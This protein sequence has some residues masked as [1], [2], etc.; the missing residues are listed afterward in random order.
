MKTPQEVT[1]LTGFLGAGKTTLLNAIVSSKP[2]TRFAII[3]NEIGEESIDAELLIQTDDNMIALNDGCIC[4]SLNGSLYDTLNEL[5]ERKSSWDH[6]LI[7]ATG[8]ADPANIA[9]PFLINPSVQDAFQLKRVICVTDAEL[10]E[11]QLKDTEVA[12]Q[13]IAFSDIILLNKT[14]KVSDIY[15]EELKA[16][17]KN[18]N[19]FAK[20]MSAKKDDLKIETLFSRERDAD[21]YSNP[22][23]FTTPKG[24]FNLIPAMPS[25]AIKTLVFGAGNSHNKHQHSEIET[26]LLRYTGSLDLVTLR[27]RMMVFVLL[28]S[29]QVYRIKGIFYSKDHAERVIFQTVGKGMSITMGKPWL[30]TEEKESKF[31]IIGK[32][33]KVHGFDKMFRECL[34]TENTAN[35]PTHYQ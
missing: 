32:N 26:I 20:I 11:D 29:A 6:L 23:P 12:I 31:V 5:W 2:D 13:Q 28:Q 25:T 3:E 15:L 10:I 9:K 21:F 34:H 24:I 7:E 22:K 19:P 1:L 33:L 35:T 14:E 16:I 30:D 17:L 27:R 18:I 4:C 8:I